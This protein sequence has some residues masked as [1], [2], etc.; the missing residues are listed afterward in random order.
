MPR[1]RVTYKRPKDDRS[2]ADI[3]YTV[4]RR[5]NTHNIEDAGKEFK[6][7]EGANVMVLHAES[8]DE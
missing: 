8:L 3:E 5:M 2:I 4:T 6:N 1:F 7:T